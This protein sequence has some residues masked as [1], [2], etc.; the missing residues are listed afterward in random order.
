MVPEDWPILLPG[1]AIMGLV[2]TASLIG[3]GT[4]KGG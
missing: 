2:L 4:R 3:D 1:A